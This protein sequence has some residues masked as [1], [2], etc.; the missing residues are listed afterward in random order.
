MARANIVPIKVAELRDALE[1]HKVKLKQQ[2][3]DE[4]K[5]KNEYAMSGMAK[6][7]ADAKDQLEAVKTR[8]PALSASLK[9]VKTPEDWEEFTRNFSRTLSRRT[10]E[11]LPVLMDHYRNSREQPAYLLRHVETQLQVLK[12]TATETINV[13]LDQYN[14]PLKDVFEMLATCELQEK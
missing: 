7:K 2:I 9:A 4:I 6:A 10:L 3:A 14:D 12:Y 1:A 11:P 8:L 5:E 13:N